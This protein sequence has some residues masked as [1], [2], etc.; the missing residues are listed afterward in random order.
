[1]LFVIDAQGSSF[2]EFEE[3][4]LQFI[5]IK[6]KSV[7]EAILKVA[8]VFIRQ[9]NNEVE[10]H[11]NFT[12]EFVHHIAC[13]IKVLFTANSKVTLFL[14]SLYANFETK[15][16]CRYMLLYKGDDIAMNNIGSYFK[17][18]NVFWAMVVQNKL[19]EIDSEIFLH[20]ECSIEELNG[21]AMLHQV[22]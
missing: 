1:M 5:G 10:V 18:E 22:E 2:Q 6:G 8:K 15:Q 17:L 20:V 3:T 16:T 7:V 12:L 4:Q 11:L 14:H 19:E 21:A 13:F 9:S